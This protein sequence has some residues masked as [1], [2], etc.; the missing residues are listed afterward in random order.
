PPR[1]PQQVEADD[2]EDPLAGPRV[3]VADVAE[4]LVE[5]RLHTRLL[6][7]L[8][9]C[10]LLG[11]LA[12]ADD[13]LRK[14]PDPRLLAARADR[15]HHPGPSQASY[16]HSTGRELPSHKTF[17]TDCHLEGLSPCT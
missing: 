17:V 10:R 11:L 4:L 12:R 13:A 14:R 16:E 2:F 1:V 5:P 8:A 15:R 6:G 9:E 3:D 7:G